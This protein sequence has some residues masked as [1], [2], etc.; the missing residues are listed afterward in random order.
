MTTAS[1]SA[2]TSPASVLRALCSLKFSIH[3]TTLK[4]IALLPFAAIYA[5]L[6]K[7]RF[8]STALLTLIVTSH[9]ALSREDCEYPDVFGSILSRSEQ[10]V[11]EFSISQKAP[12]YSS[13][14]QVQRHLSFSILLARLVRVE[15]AK[16]TYQR[17]TAMVAPDLF[18]DL[19][20]VLIHRNPAGTGTADPEYCVR[21]FQRSVLQI[22]PVVGDVSKAAADEG[23]ERF[24]NYSNSGGPLT[25]ANHI[26]MGALAQIYQPNTPMRALVS[27]SPNSVASAD[28]NTFLAWLR[29]QRSAGAVDVKPLKMCASDV[30]SLPSS[31]RVEALAASSVVSSGS[32]TM[33]ANEVGLSRSLRRVVI[34]G[35]GQVTV[36]K[37]SNSV[38]VNKYCDQRREFTIGESGQETASVRVRCLQ[39]A[40]YH[41][42]WTVLFCDPQDCSSERIEN[43][44]AASIA[45]DAGSL[46]AVT[47]TRLRGPYLV[48][49]K[50]SSSP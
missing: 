11:G 37:P 21:A 20:A 44:V 1:K 15:L 12:D 32:I 39:A 17:C 34:V 16:S 48:T 3:A 2:T 45:N 47:E 4:K 33:P 6:P 23:R 14:E 19:R 7:T 31:A 8:L 29:A 42:G 26:L 38:V 36:N 27:L 43:A 13:A 28:A 18:P 49:I 10:R 22:Q 46:R 24:E 40:V 25:D 41:D 35:H 50:A 9:G 30:S 5:S